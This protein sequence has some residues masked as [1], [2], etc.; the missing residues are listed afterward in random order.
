MCKNLCLIDC[1]FFL[2]RYGVLYL[3]PTQKGYNQTRLGLKFQIE[4]NPY[5]KQT[6]IT[7]ENIKLPLVTDQDTTADQSA[8]STFPFRII[9]IPLV[10]A[11]GIR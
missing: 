11:I 1:V 4:R 5:T 6:L 9:G 3:Y 7:M 10:M 8:I 2:H